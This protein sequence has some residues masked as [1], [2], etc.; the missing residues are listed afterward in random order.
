MM[1]RFL[2]LS[3]TRTF[4]RYPHDIQCDPFHFPGLSPKQTST[5]QPSVLALPVT[6]LIVFVLVTA[7]DG[8]SSVEAVFNMLLF[9]VHCSC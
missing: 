8:I 6:Y 3:N 5:M 9:L 1:G 4:A 2:G 7:C